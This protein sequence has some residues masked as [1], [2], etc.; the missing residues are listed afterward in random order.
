MSRLDAIIAGLA[1]SL[2]LAG[3]EALLGDTIPLLDGSSLEARV[4]S[5]NEK[6]V[7]VQW[8]WGERI[9]PLA[10]IAPAPATALSDAQQAFARKD[11]IKAADLCRLLLIHDPGNRAASDLAAQNHAQEIAFRINQFYH[12]D[13]YVVALERLK[14]IAG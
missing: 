12:R 8:A 9:I 6:R 11:F 3:A 7:T 10:Q 2:C 13:L 4:L 14:D 1:V 5:T